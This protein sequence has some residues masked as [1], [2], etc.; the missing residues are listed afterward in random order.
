MSLHNFLNFAELIIFLAIAC[1]LAFVL[2]LF[3]SPL[4]Q[5]FV[6]PILG[7]VSLLILEDLKFRISM[8]YFHGHCKQAN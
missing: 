8:R 5:V 2:P 6:L 3:L 1:L 7:G 4:I